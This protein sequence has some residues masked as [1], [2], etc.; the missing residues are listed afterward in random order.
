M[1]LASEPEFTNKHTFNLGWKVFFVRFLAYS[2][3][4][5]FKNLVL[6]LN[7]TIYS[8]PALATLGWL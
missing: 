6:E 2:I 1:S 7:F 5:G 3:I 4:L 8:H